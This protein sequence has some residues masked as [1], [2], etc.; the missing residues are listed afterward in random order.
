MTTAV[1]KSIINIIISTSW[2]GK[3]RIDDLIVEK[4]Y[5]SDRLTI[6]KDLLLDELGDCNTVSFEKLIKTLQ[7]IL[8]VNENFNKIELFEELDGFYIQKKHTN[9]NVDDKFSQVINFINS[10]ES[11][12]NKGV[13]Y[14]LFCKAFLEDLGIKCMSTKSSGDKGI[15]ILGSYHSDLKDNVANLVFNEKIYLLVQT[16]YFAS[17]IDTP[18]IRKLVGDSLFIRFDELEYLNIKHNAVHLIVFSHNGFTSPA[19]EFAKRNKVKTFDSTH[20]AHIISEEPE[21][22]WNCLKIVFP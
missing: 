4:I 14:E 1:I 20:I 5:Y 8:I 18:V 6:D 19:L 22:L 17:S 3:I 21:K 9:S 7:T 16:K 10:I 11:N 13:A 15:D 12:N 2:D